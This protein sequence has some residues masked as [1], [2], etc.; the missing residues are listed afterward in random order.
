MQRTGLT[1]A[2]PALLRWRIAI[3]QCFLKERGTLIEAIVKGT[4][5]AW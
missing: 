4:T 3:A 5:A 2:R 1:R